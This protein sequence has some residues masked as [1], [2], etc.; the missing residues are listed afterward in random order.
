MH[1]SIGRYVAM[2]GSPTGRQWVVILQVPLLLQRLHIQLQF[3]LV[4]LDSMGAASR[5]AGFERSEL[6][7]G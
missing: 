6:T 2:L 1:H 5:L 7:V 4:E 3:R